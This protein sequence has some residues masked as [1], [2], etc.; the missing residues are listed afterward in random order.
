[1][2]A[3]TPIASTVHQPTV[4]PGGP[5]LFH[6]KGAQLPAYIQH[7]ANELK[8][9]GKSESQAVQMA[10]GIVKNWARG[11][12][13]A[14][15]QVQAAAVK[16]VAEWEALKARARATPNK[17][18][19]R[20]RNLSNDDVDLVDLATVPFGSSGD[21]PKANVKTKDPAKLNTAARKSLAKKGQ[22]MPGGSSGGR[23]PIRNATDLKKAIRAVGRA[24]G[25]KA[26]VRAH[27]KKRAAALGLSSM[28]PSNWS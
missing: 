10:I 16:A 19:R 23:F 20:S 27:I 3:R 28:I 2:T 6:M 12:Q 1:M 11:G 21:G 8:K 14:S 9:K 13:G 25:S 17:G 7:V 15:P 22:A 26:A 5:G 24:K 18:E 4:K